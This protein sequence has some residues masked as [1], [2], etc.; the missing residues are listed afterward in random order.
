MANR[1]KKMYQCYITSGTTLLVIR[2][3]QIK[4]TMRY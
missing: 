2:E 4:T 1:Y 3:I